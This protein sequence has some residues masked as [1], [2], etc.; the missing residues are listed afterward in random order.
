MQSD[1]PAARAAA[2]AVGAASASSAPAIGDVGAGGSLLPPLPGGTVGK[3][4]AVDVALAM[5]YRFKRTHDAVRWPSILSKDA[6][7]LQL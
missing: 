6:L 5:A 3:S 1:V 2:T 4:E 7:S